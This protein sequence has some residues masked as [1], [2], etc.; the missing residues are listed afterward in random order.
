LPTS[1]LR[2]VERQ[3]GES[4]TVS[5]T[6]DLR[7]LARFDKRYSNGASPAALQAPSWPSR[8]CAGTRRAGTV[9][10]APGR[11]LMHEARLLRRV[12]AWPL[13][14]ITHRARSRLLATLGLVAELG[15][16]VPAA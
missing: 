16:P 1:S 15:R 5:L 8:R 6:A 4:K 3:P 11:T 2:R 10:C 9:E 12:R 13:I 7:L 14:G